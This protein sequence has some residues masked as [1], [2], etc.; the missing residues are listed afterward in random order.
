MV[1]GSVS[2]KR[3][4]TV[5]VAVSVVTHFQP[6][7]KIVIRCTTRGRNIPRLSGHAAALGQSP[8]FPGETSYSDHKVVST[9]AQ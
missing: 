2:M 6:R 1:S 4:R 8:R 3:F 9:C 5:T 7:I